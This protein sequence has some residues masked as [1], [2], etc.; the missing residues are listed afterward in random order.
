M[1]LPR[2]TSLYVESASAKF[3]C[4]FGIEQLECKARFAVE[5][6]RMGE[7]VF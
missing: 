7:G 3:S 1:H 5:R 6:T 2:W 4:G